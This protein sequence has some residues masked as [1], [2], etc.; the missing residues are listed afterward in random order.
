MNDAED[1]EDAED[2]VHS[3]QRRKKCRAQKTKYY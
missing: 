3:Q 2:Q 1:D